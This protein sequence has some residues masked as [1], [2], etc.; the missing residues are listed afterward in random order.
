MAE[1]ADIS[2]QD[3]GYMQVH[4]KLYRD[5]K[6]YDEFA[7]NA[8]DGKFQTK[9]DLVSAE[10]ETIDDPAG[11]VDKVVPLLINVAKDDY[12]IAMLIPVHQSSEWETVVVSET[13]IVGFYCIQGNNN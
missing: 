8:V 4:I 6:L 9:T 13:Y 11:L 10:F 2:I 1:E 7:F 12:T 3:I 5:E